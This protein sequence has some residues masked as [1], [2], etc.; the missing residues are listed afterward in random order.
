M[1]A[2]S[3]TKCDAPPA[4]ATGYVL[5]IQNLSVNDGEGI[6]TVIFL[7]G[8]PLRCRWCANPE[9]W[10]P[11]PKLA[12]YHGKC[13]GCGTC[14]WACPAS[15]FPPHAEDPR[16]AGCTACGIC[17]R[18]CPAGALKI[19]NQEMSLDEIGR[20][21]ERDAVF[22]RASGGGV[23]FSGGEPTFQTAFLRS[24]TN[25]F[26]GRGFD[27]CIET[28][29]CFNWNEVEDIFAKFNHVFYDIKHMDPAAHRE[30]TGVSNELI[31]QNCV[32]VSRSGLPVTVRVPVIRG[33]NGTRENLAATA[34]FISRELEAASV[35]LLPYHN[36][37]AEKYRA[38]G[39]AARRPDGY[40]APEPEEMEEFENLFRRAGV[41][42][43]R[44][45]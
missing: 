30:L 3:T 24:L 39:L 9:T 17:V 6:R 20:K 44:Y 33:L 8:C 14:S 28:C 27:L 45:R 15:I 36:L 18:E 12:V 43:V 10:T 29:G 19:L 5:Q 16:A 2:P 23:T 26:Y 40:A 1:P 22:F 41:P 21:V 34:R 35:E 31:L 4:S 13:T 32:R 37:G 11:E 25:F 42:V 7:P 38:I